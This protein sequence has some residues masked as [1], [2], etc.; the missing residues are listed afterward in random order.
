MP[1]LVREKRAD[2]LALPQ[3]GSERRQFPHTASTGS[4]VRE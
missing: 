1:I 3:Y 4:S 2:R